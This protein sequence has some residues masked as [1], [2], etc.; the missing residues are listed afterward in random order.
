MKTKLNIKGMHWPVALGEL[1]S[2]EILLRKSHDK[3]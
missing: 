3:W 1:L 2:S